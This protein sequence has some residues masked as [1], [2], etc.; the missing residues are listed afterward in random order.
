MTSATAQPEVSEVEAPFVVGDAVVHPRHGAGMVFSRRPRCLLGSVCDYPEI[1]LAH[2]S[3]RILVPCEAVG[4]VALRS[5]VDRRRLARIVEVLEDESEVVP[6]SWPARQK[7]CREKLKGG[8]VL[9]LAAMVRDLAARAAKSALPA[10]ERELDERSRRLLG[11]ELCCA[12]GLDR[13]H[14]AAYID[15]PVACGS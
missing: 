9:E 6:P 14:A 4:A 11:S 3:L 5:V 13:V 1:E 15:E 7:R 12:L 8:D 2:A 10:S